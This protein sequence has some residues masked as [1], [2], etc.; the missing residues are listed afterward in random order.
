MHV[1][2]ALYIFNFLKTDIHIK[3]HLFRAFLYWGCLYNKNPTDF[4]TR[5]I[6]GIKDRQ[7]PFMYSFIF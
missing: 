3:S 4:I 7:N 1:Y 5:Q 6:V 2:K